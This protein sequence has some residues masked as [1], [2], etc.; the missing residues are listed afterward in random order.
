MITKEQA[1]DIINKF[2]FFYGNRAGRELWFDKAREVQDADVKNFSD[3]CVRLLEY[4]MNTE[5][6]LPKKFWIVFNVPGFYNI[7]EY[8]V[9]RISIA[10]G[11]IDKMWGS[12]KT[13][14]EVVYKEHF[15]S[16]VFFSEEAAKLG[17]EKLI[18]EYRNEET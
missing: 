12:N 4:V 13:S 1:I 3:D 8:D 5:I 15:G 17:L 7:K 18:E 11:V 9:D 2:D 14:K 16:L 6:E 10:N